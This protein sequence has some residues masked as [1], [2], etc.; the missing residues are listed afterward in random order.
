MEFEKRILDLE[1]QIISL[2]ASYYRDMADRWKFSKDNYHP[3]TGV[4]CVK[5]AEEL[6]FEALAKRCR[7]C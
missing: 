2:K 5:E 7:G 1:K 4:V 6:L 3:V